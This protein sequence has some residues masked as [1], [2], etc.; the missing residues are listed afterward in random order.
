MPVANRP[1]AQQVASQQSNVAA[2]AV[3]PHLAP[4]EDSGHAIDWDLEKQQVAG[5]MVQTPKTRVFGAHPKSGVEEFHRSQ[6]AHM[7]GESYVDVYGDTIA[8]ISESCYILSEA[9][10]LGTPEVF[11]HMQPTRVGCVRQGPSEGELFKDLP[12]VSEASIRSKG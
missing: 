1:P 3:A 8:W 6:P 4:P 5:A 12:R 9:P 2:V 10:Q 7:A 11:K